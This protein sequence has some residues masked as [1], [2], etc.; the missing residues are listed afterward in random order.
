MDYDEKQPY[1]HYAGKHILTLILEQLH[2]VIRT[3]P[4]C[5]E[6]FPSRA[7]YCPYC[8]NDIRAIIEERTERLKKAT[9]ELLSLPPTLTPEEQERKW[10][11]VFPSS[12][13]YIYYHPHEKYKIGKAENVIRRMAKH[14]CSAPS[15]ELL[16][17][18]ETSDLD[19][20]ERFLHERFRH[21]RIHPNHEYFDLDGN[22]IRWLFSIKVLDPPRSEAAQLNLLDL[23]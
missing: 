2:K 20:C 15:A 18:I 4:Q 3:C 16:H 12:G 8:G 6:E 11:Y 14:E 23:L 1:N 17:V 19:W 5:D 10:G 22:D 21:R 7:N 9:E 13:I